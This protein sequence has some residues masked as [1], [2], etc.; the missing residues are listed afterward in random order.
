MRLGLGMLETPVGVIHRGRSVIREMR[1]WGRRTAGLG[2]RDQLGVWSFGWSLACLVR[3][4]SPRPRLSPVSP[5]RTF[6]AN[7]LSHGKGFANLRSGWWWSGRWHWHA[8]HPSEDLVCLATL[9]TLTCRWNCRYPRWR[10]VRFCWFFV[11]DLSSSFRRGLGSRNKHAFVPL[12]VAIPSRELNSVTARRRLAW[13]ATSWRRLLAPSTKARKPSGG[14]WS[15]RAHVGK[16]G[17][18][19]TGGGAQ[20]P[21]S[22]IFLSLCCLPFSILHSRPRLPV[23]AGLFCGLVSSCSAVCFSSVTPRL[24]PQSTAAQ[25]EMVHERAAGRLDDQS[26][27]SGCALDRLALGLSLV[28]PGVLLTHGTWEH[29]LTRRFLRACPLFVQPTEIKPGGAAGGAA[30]ADSPPYVSKEGLAQVMANTAL[31]PRE[32]SKWEIIDCF[33]WFRCG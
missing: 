14:L 12:G 16:N 32:A 10:V 23:P 28:G 13:E 5:N 30:G 9:P 18:M 8:R 22:G 19:V 6:E 2:V 21:G 25:V 1:G 24:I 27:R 3:K 7:G 15:H 17:T 26:K 31:A 20:L 4:C 33:L 29:G 11:R